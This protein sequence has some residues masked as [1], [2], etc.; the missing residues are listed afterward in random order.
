MLE[1][2][3]LKGLI[4]QTAV[5]LQKGI[6][7]VFGANVIN[8]IVAMVSSMAITR[9]L[10]QSDYGLWSYVLN[11]YS[12]LTLFTGFGLMSGAFQFGAENK[13][14]EEEFQFFKYCMN[15][16]LKIDGVLVLGFVA[17]ASFLQFSFPEANTFAQA[18][19]PLLLLEYALN[20]LLTV[21]RCENRIPEYAGIINCN[22]V[23]IAAGTCGGA[24]FGIWG[25]IIGRYGATILSLLQTLLRTRKE[26]IKIQSA[27]ALE[28]KY[29]KPLWHY[30]LF[31]GTSA[32]LNLILYTL[33][34]TMIAAMIADPKEVAFY[35]VATLIPTSLSFIPSSVIT[36]VLPNVIAHSGDK[37][38][39]KRNTRKMMLCLGAFNLAVCSGLILLAPV[40]ICTISGEQYRESVPVFRVL[41]VGYFFSGTFRSLCTNILA[42]LK[43]VKF[44]LIISV[45]SGICDIIFNLYMIKRYGTI[46]AAYA[47][48]GVILAAS[49]L[50]VWYLCRHIMK[51]DKKEA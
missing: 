19:A 34:V 28:E 45:V 36:A 25:V 44:N 9:L 20:M 49:L 8:K 22:T 15:M 43:C 24:M 10:S 46:G 30:S 18:V 13:G 14:R 48:V 12:Y 27:S 6:L 3:R 16:G 5:Q 7:Q 38:W 40:I 50:A 4:H 31:T 32:V 37:S 1:T 21:L 17:A 47:T 11:I 33:D 51:M 39:L 23:L 26:A 29:R 2:D 42:G 41:V 35:K